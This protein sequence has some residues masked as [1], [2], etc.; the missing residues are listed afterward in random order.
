MEKNIAYCGLNCAEC[1]AYLATVNDD[2]ALREKTAK[3]WSELNQVLILPKDIHCEGCRT[4]GVKTLFCDQ[5]C[6]IRKCAVQKGVDTCGGC[7][8]LEA[9]QKISMIIENNAEARENLK[10]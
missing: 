7:P 2:Q 5:L 4:N 10:G 6:E 1:D 9:C 3:L 8:E